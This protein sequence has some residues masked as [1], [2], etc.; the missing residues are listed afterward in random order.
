MCKVPDYET[1]SAECNRPEIIAGDFSIEFK[2]APKLI[3][4]SASFMTDSYYQ[5]DGLEKSRLNCKDTKLPNI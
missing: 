1:K 5:V 3:S 2:K 4:P